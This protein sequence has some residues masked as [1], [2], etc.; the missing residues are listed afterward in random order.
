[1]YLAELTQMQNRYGFP[2]PQP[3]HPNRLLP[4]S[5]K[6]GLAGSLSYVPSGRFVGSLGGPP[7]QMPDYGTARRADIAALSLGAC[8]GGPCFDGLAGIH[9][10]AGAAS[11]ARQACNI[12]SDIGSATG[13]IGLLFAD[14]DSTAATNWGRVDSVSQIAGDTICQAGADQAGAPPAAAV[15]PNQ[16]AALMDM[17]GRNSAAQGGGYVGGAPAPA[18]VAKPNYLLYAGIGAAVIGGIVLLRRR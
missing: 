7:M 11:R 12:A 15:D 14:E 10:L 8:R 17:W 5:Q 4:S 18:P 16:Q 9:G 6:C 1:M 3:G 13:Q 2:G